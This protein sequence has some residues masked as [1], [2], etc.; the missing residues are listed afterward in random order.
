MTAT[1]LLRHGTCAVLREGR[2]IGTAWLVSR[3][4]HLL[5]AGHVVDSNRS[6]ETVTIRFPEDIPRTAYVT[7]RGYDPTMGIDFA[8]LKLERPI[9]ESRPLPITLSRE[10]TG[11]FR[12][13]GYGTTLV[14]QS[15]GRGDFISPF[16]PQDVTGFRLFQ[17]RSPELGEHGFSGGAVFSEDLQAVV[18]VQIEATTQN[19]GAGRD[20]LLAMPLYRIAHLWNQLERFDRPDRKTACIFI[21]YKRGVEPDESVAWSLYEAL[22]GHHDVFIDRKMKIGVEWARHI[23]EELKRADFFIPLLSESSVHSEMVCSEI[24]TAYHL[25]RERSEKGNPSILP[26]RLRYNA[27]FAYPLSTYLNPINWACWN[28]PADTAGLVDELMTA[29]SF[30][31]FGPSEVKPSTDDRTGSAAAPS[32]PPPLSAAQLEMPGGTMDTESKFYMERPQDIHAR[33]VMEHQGVTV[34]IKGPRQVGKSSLLVRMVTSA[35]KIGKHV[36]LIDFQQ[37]GMNVLRAPDLFY[38]E[39]CGIL[40]DTFDLPNRVDEYWKLP[41]ADVRRS[42][43]YMERYILKELQSSLVLAMDEVDMIFDTSYRSDFFG[44]LRSWHNARALSSVWKKLDM[45]LVTSTEPYQ[46]IEDLSQSPFNVGETIEPADFTLQQVRDLTALH[47]LVIDLADRLHVELGGHPYLTR[48][49][50]YL[51]TNRQ[52]S[53]DDFFATLYEDR[54]PFGEHLRSHLFRLH[55]KPDL[56]QGLL[57]VIRTGRCDDDRIAFRL[58]GGGLVL[59]GGGKTVFPRCRMYAEYFLA[60]LK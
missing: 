24:E 10:V 47:G 58:Q 31:S 51:L 21:S 2:P 54:G 32:L 7:I 60:N 17:L 57:Q 56:I 3:E 11:K 59:K 42:T 39:F 18:G 9:E 13:H 16:D 53:V 12:V 14:D 5:T 27:P 15:V 20:T 46:F 44:L 26:V 49:A 30:G 40:S 36:V 48:K 28:S 55:D 41:L 34:T 45:I 29:I 4:G 8:V 43:R 50:L 25:A 38:R 52:M 1:D 35:Q 6:D 22:A 23:E 37:I 33:Q 19:T